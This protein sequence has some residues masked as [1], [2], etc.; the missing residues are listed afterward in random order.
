[1]TQQQ[2]CAHVFPLPPFHVTRDH[3]SIVAETIEAMQHPRKFFKAYVWGFWPL[4]F[5]IVPPGLMLNLAYAK[6]L[7]A[8][9]E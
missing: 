6:T 1:M 7:G 8:A 9:C 5:M 4:V 3:N 2:C